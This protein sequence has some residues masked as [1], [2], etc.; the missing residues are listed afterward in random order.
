[1]D[2]RDEP[3]HD[4]GRIHASPRRIAP[5]L[6][7]YPSPKEGVGNA[8]CT[9]AP[10]VS[11]GKNKNH[12]SVVTAGRRRF[13]PAFPHA[14][15][16]N[17]FL[18]ALPGDRALLPP[19]PRNAKAL[20]RVDASVGASGPHDF[21]V[22]FTRHSSKAPK[23]PP[24]PAPNVRDDRE[25]PL[26]EGHGTAT[27]MEV[28]WAKREAKYFFG[29][30]WTDSISLNGLDKFADWCKSVEGRFSFRRHFRMVRK[31][32]AR[33]LERCFASRRRC[34]LL[35]VEPTCRSG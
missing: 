23:R 12:T 28:I 35:R 24:H 27:K 22:R 19:S 9:S 11:R 10:A 13:H 2:G 6:L 33:N 34:P 26:V 21:A 20:S 8:G 31:H 16:F 32:Q 3:G 30:D 7:I 29:G 25:T 18:R 5:E 14:N 4:E 17:G 1:V 15:G